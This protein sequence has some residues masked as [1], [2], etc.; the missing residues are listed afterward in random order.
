MM[1]KFP[2]ESDEDV[3]QMFQDTVLFLGQDF[4]PL[5]LNLWWGSDT[6]TWSGWCLCP[7][8]TFSAALCLEHNA[9]SHLIKNYGNFAYQ[10]TSFF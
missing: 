4:P 7:F 8:G 10:R 6:W 2:V 9:L 1:P 5:G 3:K